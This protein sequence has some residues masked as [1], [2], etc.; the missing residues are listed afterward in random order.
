MQIKCYVNK[1]YFANYFLHMF[2][3][4]FGKVGN[5]MVVLQQKSWCNDQQQG[6][7]ENSLCESEIT[8]YEAHQ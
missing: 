6:A 2:D 8:A 7:G 1:E 3:V 5:R 4:I